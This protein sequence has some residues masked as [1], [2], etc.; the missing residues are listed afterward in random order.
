MFP[1]LGLTLSLRLISRVAP[2]RLTC[3]V[4]GYFSRKTFD[5][6]I[7]EQ[8]HI[9]GRISRVALPSHPFKIQLYLSDANFSI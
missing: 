4:I 1:M 6:P 5:Y 8:R 2:K 9:E 7:A 3:L